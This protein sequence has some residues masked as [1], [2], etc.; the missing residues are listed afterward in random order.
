MATYAMTIDEPSSQGR[1]L[2]TY[3]G[4]LNIKLQPLTRVVAPC[5]FSKE[6]MRD[7]LAESTAEARRGMGTSHEDF[8]REMA[9]WL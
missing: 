4:T 6:E 1:A 7:M 9:S 5:Q 3:L 2:L 8:K